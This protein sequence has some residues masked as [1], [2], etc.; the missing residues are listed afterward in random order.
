MVWENLSLLIK[1]SIKDSLL[2]IK[3][4]ETGNWY[5]RM[6]MFSRDNLLMV[7]L[8]ETEF[9]GS[10]M[11]SNSKDILRREY[12]YFFYFISK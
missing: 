8:L 2:I 11:E 1:P 5:L 4:L 6:E 3:C 9:I 7:L 10:C 12:Q